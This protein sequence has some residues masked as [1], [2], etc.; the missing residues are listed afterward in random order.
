MEWIEFF[1]AACSATIIIFV[2]GMIILRSFGT[3]YAQSFSYAP[4]ISVAIYN[5]LAILFSFIGLPAFFST[6]FFPVVGFSSILYFYT[7]RRS[8]QV[9]AQ[10]TAKKRLSTV[11]SLRNELFL[12][13][14]FCFIGIVIGIRFF[15]LPLDGPDSFVQ[16][17][18]N[19][20]HLA[21]IRSFVDSN[22]Y[23]TLE[24]GLYQDS[25]AGVLS[26]TASTGTGFYPAAWHCLCALVSSSLNL[27]IPLTANAVN[28]VL[29]SLVFPAAVFS[30]LRSIYKDNP[31]YLVFSAV[32][33][34]AFAAFPWGALYPSA[35][36]LYPN[37]V[38]F[39][40]LPALCACIICL[41]DQTGDFPRLWITILTLIFGTI[42]CI[43][44]HPNVFFSAVVLLFPFCT[45]RLY[46]YITEKRGNKVARAISLLF[47]ATIAFLWFV[48]YSLPFMDSIVHF[49]WE[50]ISDTWG[51]LLAVL[52]L[53][54]GMI[55]FPQWVLGGLVLLGVLSVLGSARLRWIACTWIFSAFLF[56]VCAS[57][58]GNLENLL[59]GF[60]YTDPNRVAFLV[61]LAGVM[62][63]PSGVGLLAKVFF[64]LPVILS[65]G[66]KKNQKVWISRG[67]TCAAV[68][69]L[70]FATYRSE[71]LAWGDGAT[72]AFGNL[73]YCF[74]MANN[75]TRANTFDPEERSFVKKVAKIVNPKYK[76]YN[77]AD[78]GSS[79]AYATDGLNLCYRRSGA[80]GDSLAGSVLR[81]WINDLGCNPEIREIVDEANIKY[82]LVLDYGGKV[83]PERCYYGYYW[84]TR[85]LGI[86]SITDSTPGLKLLLSEGDMR[87]YEIE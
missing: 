83:L 84:R 48:A 27:S 21:L 66:V 58:D 76:I 87:L 4:L 36:P 32:F 57:T 72:T 1:A 56:V 43:F 39:C 9:R 79:F 16:D 42:S 67:I 65:R 37:F 18:D 70:V 7:H 44:A 33:A 20:Y 23:S 86:N 80:D 3:G 28:F 45:N 17:S 19:S 50:P 2:P 51:A 61:A 69:I 26:L 64:K 47:V 12:L 73:E 77:C 22:N 71:N 62:L 15:V 85:W 14:L 10:L 81:T 5:A 25:D 34:C 6:L 8:G 59:T 11:I 60:W 13:G 54:L 29:L 31:L 30:L 75:A 78:D 41:I 68:A 49:E 35:G 74:D 63:V 38:G 46:T 52:S 55:Q 53:S 24:T 82:V 40:M